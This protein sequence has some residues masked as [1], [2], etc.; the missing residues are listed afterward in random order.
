MGH[1]QYERDRMGRAE[2]V[3][4]G[5]F[6][7]GSFATLTLTYTA[8]TY[9]IDDTGSIKIAHRFASD[10][11]KP[12]FDDPA[13]P[14]YVAVEASNG[15]ELELRY[16]PKQ[17]I[18]PWDKTL[19]VKVVRGF[20]REGDRLVV[21]FGD[22]RGGSPGMRLQTFCE[23]RFTFRVLV[24]AFATYDY[25]ELPDPP[26]IS[27]VPGPPV[28]FRAVLPTLRR[29]GEPFTL[30]V[31]GEDRWGNPSDRCDHVFTLRANLEVVGL[32]ERLVLRPGMFAAAAA[33]LRVAEPGDLVIELLDRRGRVVTASNPL[34]VAAVELVSW[35]AD[36]HGQS[37]ET[38]GTNSARAYFRFARDR[39]FLDVTG[40]QGNDFQITRE[41]WAEL[42]SLSREFD[43][44]GRF[45]VLPGYEWSG[46]TGLGGDRNVF[47]ARE[48]RPIRRSSHA[49][50]PDLSDAHTDVPTAEAL[51]GALREEDC[52]VI[53]HVGGRYADLRRA[54]DGRLERSVE[55]HSAWGTFE[56]LLHDAFELGYRVGVVC[57]SDGHK[58]RPGASHPGASMFGAYGGLTCLF[59][60]ELTRPAIFEAYR[61][62]HH[63][64][65]TGCR[66]FLDLRVR[67]AEPAELF[68][69]DPALGPTASRPV[70]EAMMGDIL[71][72]AGET[73]EL[74]VEVL[75]AAPVE[76][77]EIRNGR[78][79]L[80]TFRPYGEADLGARIRVIWEGARYRGRGRQTV[81]D[82]YAE[83]EG[84]GFAGLAPINFWNL[85]QRFARTA[86][87][88]V[89]WTA[90]TTGNFAGLEA[91]L[92]D[93]G[94][95]ILRIDT[96]LVR[97]ALPI[98]GIGRE[99]TVF[100]A[101]G[102]GRR[103]RVFRLP[104]ANPHR[105]VRLGRRIALR[106]SGDNPLWVC[107][108]FE[109]GHRAW[110]SPVYLFRDEGTGR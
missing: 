36:I 30:Q 3:P 27:I 2:I 53:A 83:L 110:T 109:D 15:A 24:D 56:W 108:T 44:D 60:R 59:A 17:N 19:Y 74:A 28:A 93:P 14:N 18:R 105:R 90:L 64:G 73:V 97:C 25:V 98:A 68:A 101:G 21:R 94:S 107:V 6:E 32:P 26:A 50:V 13:A 37:E 69:E 9:G 46:N 87:D 20:L 77:I 39:G 16:D 11:G 55:I 82:G 75:A 47:F 91:R 92:E 67:F 35:W 89:E 85:E 102:L 104:D 40:H 49:L 31:K 106:E 23:E 12:Q 96:P 103:L 10:T 99:D 58:G 41:F 4:G 48:G 1:S 57:N 29:P 7:A 78:E 33:G 38:I 95:G 71:R 70:R 72:V 45:V 61:R 80:E 34:R 65:T 52:I 84:N 88:R 79:T 100:E 62:R 86:P 42:Q 8:G 63:Y 43:E 76:R 81:W 22:R 66:A 54:H 5:A 51:F